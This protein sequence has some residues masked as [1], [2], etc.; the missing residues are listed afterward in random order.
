MK[1]MQI[2]ENVTEMFMMQ[3][4]CLCSKRNMINDKNAN[5]IHCIISSKSL[6]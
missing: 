1:N 2:D 4:V 5:D 6:A 3:L